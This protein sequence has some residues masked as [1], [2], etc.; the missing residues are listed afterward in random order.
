MPVETGN[1][2]QFAY[3]PEVAFGTT[4]ATPT[5]QL[6]R[7]IPSGTDMG[8]DRSFVK[9]PELRTDFQTAPGAAGGLRG[10]GTLAGKLSY[11]SY[12]DWMGYALGN[13]AWQANVIKIVPLTSTGG[14]SL[15][16]DSS[17]KTF[18]RTVGSFVTDGFVVGQI[19]NTGG[20][21]NAAN[22]GAFVVSA[23]SALVLTCS[24]ATTL[25]TEAA[26]AGRSI[27]V[28]TNPS[29]TLERGHKGNGIFFPFTGVVVDGFEL[30]GKVNEPVDIKFNLLSKTVGNESATSVF[31]ALTAANTNDLISTWQGTIKRN[32][33]AIGD[34]TG[35]SLKVARNS[36]IAEVCGNADV[37]DIQ[38]KAVS[39][40][41]SMEIYFDSMQHYTDFRQQNDVAFQLN[42]GSG[43]SKSYTI[44][45]TRCR[46]TKWGAPPK[47]G[48]MTSTVEFEADV[49]VSGTNTAL[50]ITRIP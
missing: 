31:S 5:G 1:K 13:A 50:M 35:W 23:V 22:N 28:D 8:A 14:I 43:T 48:M 49:P 26:S 17:A 34:V 21:T 38:P 9:N 36:D 44:D 24:T 37:Y 4:P 15:A 42:L 41:G 25:V 12:D 29:F 40:T 47:D 3:V 32:A 2:T 6:L 10:K 20:F 7:W 33:T 46:I 18:T 27:A 16:V 19:I 45:L 39:V 11:G 30:S